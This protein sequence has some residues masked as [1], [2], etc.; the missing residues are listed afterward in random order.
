[1]K[2][3]PGLK[4]LGFILLVLTFALGIYAAQEKEKSK[5]PVWKQPNIIIK[6]G[7]ES[8]TPSLSDPLEK[9]TPKRAEQ[10]IRLFQ[11]NPDLYV[12]HEYK[13]GVIVNTIGGLKT[14]IDPRPVSSSP[15]PTPTP[16]P[17][18]A[19]G[20]SPTTPAPS[21]TVS[22]MGTKTQTSLA[23]AVRIDR[24]EEFLKAVDRQATAE[25]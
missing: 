16:T 24:V 19:P 1:M 7:L 20:L 10:L 25:K 21:P 2:N 6:V 17:T 12:I 15:T 8:D 3:L 22:P 23:L 18:P 13:D 4:T 14:C 5:P 9:L 11:K